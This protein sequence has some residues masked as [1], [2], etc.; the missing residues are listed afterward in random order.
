MAARIDDA[1]RQTKLYFQVKKSQT[2]D[3]YK[4]DEAYIET[5][6]GNHIKSCQVDKGG[7]FLSAQMVNH[8]DSK[9]TKCKLTVHDSPPQNGVSERGMR[10]Q[11]EQAHALLLAS[12]LPWFLWKEAIKHSAWL[13]D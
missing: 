6:S 4:K 13:Q 8:Q 5:Q 3:L 1:T 2:F 10:T 9:G 11:A 12:G 7:E